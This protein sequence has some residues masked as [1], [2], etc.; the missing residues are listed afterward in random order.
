MEDLKTVIRDPE[1]WIYLI[2]IGLGIVILFT[3]VLNVC[4][5]MFVLMGVLMLVIKYFSIRKK[6]LAES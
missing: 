6:R 3:P 2:A 4:G 1:T 5:G